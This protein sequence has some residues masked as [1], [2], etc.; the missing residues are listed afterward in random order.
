MLDLV[1]TGKCDVRLKERMINHYSKPKGFVGRS[2]CYAVFYDG[3]YY[4][5]IVFGSSTMHL[6]G[7]H[8]FFGTTKEQLN[9]I[10]N[11]VFYNVTK[12]ADKYP[13][14]NF[15]TFVLTSAIS[16]ICSDWK[17]KYG[18]EV[19]GVETLVELP[20][21]GELYLRG[22]FT[23]VG[24]T[25]GYSCKRTAGKGSDEWGGKRVWCKDE[26][27]LKPKI[28]LCKKCLTK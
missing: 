17:T 21:T 14:R 26:D 23:V 3:V 12:V 24:T 9:N 7:R 19:V 1:I 11:N 6:P 10:V 13:V 18:D 15:T 22:G 25:K 2:I 4:G 28:V 5:H 8:D 16:R 27:K 20:R